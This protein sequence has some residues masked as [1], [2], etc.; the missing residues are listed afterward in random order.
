MEQELRS[1]TTYPTYS[2]PV[3]KKSN[4]TKIIFISVIIL[5]LIITSIFFL[6]KLLKEK[7]ELQEEVEENEELKKFREEQINK[8]ISNK[9][10]YISCKG[11]QEN[12]E[13]YCKTA[14]NNLDS[15]INDP[16]KEK[17]RCLFYTKLTSLIKDNTPEKCK[18]IAD[19]EGYDKYGDWQASICFILA[20]RSKE[21]CK[22]ITEMPDKEEFIGEKEKSCN[23]VFD[24]LKNENYDFK[25]W[26]EEDIE[27]FIAL[28]AIKLK[29]TK[30][31][32]K[33]QTDHLRLRCKIWVED[34]KA[35]KDNFCDSLI[36]H[37]YDPKSYLTEK[38]S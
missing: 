10:G 20:A 31:C 2:E 21:D 4:T 19:M 23:T 25:D 30:L 15:A 26:G 16:L 6:P 13:D 17:S 14:Y 18:E 27:F 11:F 28:K 33:I 1:Q 32:E 3:V 37:C 9:E 7:R 38:S 24:Y 22:G 29:D 5:I 36:E 35:Q 8:C 12:S 34:P